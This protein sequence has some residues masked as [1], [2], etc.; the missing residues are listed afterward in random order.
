MVWS[1]WCLV[2]RSEVKGEHDYLDFPKVEYTDD[3]LRVR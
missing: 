1:T 3:E 2:M